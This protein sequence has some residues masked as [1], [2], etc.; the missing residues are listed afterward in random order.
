MRD[1]AAIWAGDEETYAIDWERIHAEAVWINAELGRGDH[2]RGP[3]LI[4]AGG[5]QRVGFTVVPDH[6]HG[7]VVWSATAAAVVWSLF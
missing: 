1:L 6:G 3:R 7:D 2:A 4:R 5:N